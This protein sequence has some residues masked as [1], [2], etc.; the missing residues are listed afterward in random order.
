MLV[1]RM[2]VEVALGESQHK[3]QKRRAGPNRS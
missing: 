1:R 2:D 3:V